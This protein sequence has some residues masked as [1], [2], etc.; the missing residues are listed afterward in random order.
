MYEQVSDFSLYWVSHARFPKFE[1]VAT[2]HN[3]N[4]GTERGEQGGR[5]NLVIRRGRGE[6]GNF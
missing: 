6:R 1:D 4:S 2:K 5:G 3:L